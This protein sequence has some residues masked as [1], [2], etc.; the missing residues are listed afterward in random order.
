MGTTLESFAALDSGPPDGRSAP[1]YQ[2]GRGSGSGCRA[3]LVSVM[4]WLLTQ[5]TRGCGWRS[6]VTW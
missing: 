6:P 1:L 4:A 2:V 5:V 3:L